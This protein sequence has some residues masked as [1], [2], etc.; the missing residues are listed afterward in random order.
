MSLSER[1]RI[2]ITDALDTMDSIAAKIILSGLESFAG[3]LA[4]ELPNIFRKIRDRIRD[5]WHWFQG[6]F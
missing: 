2:I 1:D 6:L 3:W 4:R 5:I